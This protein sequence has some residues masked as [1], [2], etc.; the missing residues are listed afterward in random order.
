MSFAEI[1]HKT[2][3]D[4]LRGQLESISP[5]NVERALSGFQID[6]SDFLSLISPVATDYLEVMAQKARSITLQR[7]GKV[8]LLYAPL[9]L[10]N[11]CSNSCLYCGFNVH[12]EVPRITL[13]VD[14]IMAEASQLKKFG[15]GH[16]L[17]VCGEAPKQVPV[18]RLGEI[19]R[20]LSKDFP[21]LSLEIYPLSGPAYQ[22]MADAGADGLTLYQETY[23]REVYAS[24]HPSGRKRD[25]DWRLHAAERAGEAGF[26]RLG[27][28]ALL[29][30]H[31]WRCEAIAVALHAEYLMKRYWR[32]QVTIS[33]PRLRNTP[34][35]FQ[36]P[37]P[38]RDV[39]LV[40]L[41]LALRL[42]LHDA[43]IV[44]STREPAEFRDKLMPLGVTQMS[45]G[46]RTEPGGY[47]HPA[48]KSAQFMVNDQRSPLEVAEAI[49]K[50]GYDPLWKDWD[51]VMHEGMIDANHGQWDAQ[52][53]L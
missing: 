30:L 9:Y 51:Q 29:G 33:F 12:R 2:D 35:G 25:F 48:E 15:F 17:L 4:R 21:S 6:F 53:S 42:Y 19:L 31:D 45:A 43:G 47:L 13:S 50:A 18:A 39:E 32:T 3:I 14:E 22:Q 34:P 5:A 38:V 36:I 49:Q 41:M 28:G 8:I 26:R 40:Q 37:M 1:L 16:V 24:V 23:N 27:I 11:E 7:F 20:A 46:S 52:G 44:V 10:S